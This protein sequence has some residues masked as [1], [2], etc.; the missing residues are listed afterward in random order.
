MD[1]LVTGATGFVGAR[2]CRRLLERG[3]RVTAF[4]R[5]SSDLSVLHSLELNHAIGDLTDGPSIMQAL[6]GHE[7]VIH[8]AAD[9][10]Q[11]PRRE[12]ALDAA[13]VRGTQGVI[14]GCRETGVRRLV[15]VSSVVT[16]GIPS[17]PG[18]PAD[19]TLPFNLE[20]TGLTYHLSKKRAE[21]EVLR[22]AQDGLDAVVVNPSTICGRYRHTFR[23][24]DVFTR[25]LR[26]RIVPYFVGGRNV[27]HVNDIADG[28]L[29]ALTR[30]RAGERYILGGE[31][32]TYRRMAEIAAAAFGLTPR[33]LVP[34][35][36]LVTGAAA[37]AFEALGVV[38]GRPP[39]I[40]REAHY[41]ARRLLYYNSSKAAAE[42]DYS[43]RSYLAIVEDYKKFSQRSAPE[44]L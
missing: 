41:F 38:T 42:L 9:L 2:V 33:I 14:A 44:S 26:S 43:S 18:L 31:N 34:L 37:L 12:S 22:A 1:I 20:R 30:G 39:K 16:I 27:V 8:A 23:G 29:S 19:E 25:V 13:N 15:H 10:A 7:A 24:S 17:N 28:I 6:R 3:H 36:P 35:P 21:D 40:D 5:P 4:H 11:W 32:L